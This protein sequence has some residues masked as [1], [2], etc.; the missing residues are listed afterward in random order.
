MA[1]YT[2]TGPITSQYYEIVGTSTT[3]TTSG[4]DALLDSMTVTPRA[5]TY[6]CNF[7]TSVNNDLGG[8]VTSVSLYVGGVQKAAT[9]MQTAVF[10]GG[11]LSAL[12]ATGGVAITSII[13]F[14]GATALDVSWSVTGGTATCNGRTLTLVRI[15]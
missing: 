9:L 13:I 11:T 8:A 10:D 3:T 12:S 4:T 14:D 2:I 1:F 5:G 7:T 15:A 6:L